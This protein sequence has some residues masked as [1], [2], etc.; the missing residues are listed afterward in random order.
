[1]ACS[2]GK[3]LEISVSFDESFAAAEGKG[4]C[5]VGSRGSTTIT[6]GRDRVSCCK[7]R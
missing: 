6:N 5:Y 4:L 3:I 7:N 1:M 2:D